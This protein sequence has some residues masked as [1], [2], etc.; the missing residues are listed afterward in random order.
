MTRSRA[1]VR[2]CG[3]GDGAHILA[4]EFDELREKEFRLNFTIPTREELEKMRTSYRDITRD[5]RKKVEKL[6]ASLDAVLTNEDDSKVL[7]KSLSKK[8][9]DK[10]LKVLSDEE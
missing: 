1:W 5:E 4:S 3:H 8:L 7:M 6:E 2:I 10:L 9:R